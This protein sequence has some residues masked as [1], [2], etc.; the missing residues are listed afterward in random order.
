MHL[1]QSVPSPR[2]H[3][4][5]P[6]NLNHSPPVFVVGHGSFKAALATK[7]VVVFSIQGIA[8]IV[9]LLRGARLIHRQQ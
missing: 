2:S 8:K 9:P 4:G 3:S 7:I 6:N 1:A 5:R